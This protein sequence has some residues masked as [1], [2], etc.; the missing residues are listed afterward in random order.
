MTAH[1]ELKY[2]FTEEARKLLPAYLESSKEVLFEDVKNRKY[3]FGDDMI[4]ITASD[5]KRAIES[6]KLK[7]FLES[8]RRSR[9]A[10]VRILI[11]VY[12]VAGVLIAVFGSFAPQISM[13]I[14]QEPLRGATLLIGAG[15]AFIG[16]VMSFLLTQKE[17]MRT[18]TIEVTKTSEPEMSLEEL[19]KQINELLK[20]IEELQ[21]KGGKE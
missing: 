1:R 14:H 12:I 5:I 17:G 7:S 11:Q 10:K 18:E 21:G 9:N 6:I 15:M 19:S 2:V 4:E 20:Q 13:Y 8:N 3:V 16:G